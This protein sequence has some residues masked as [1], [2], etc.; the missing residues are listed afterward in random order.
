MPR[1]A[2]RP[3]TVDQFVELVEDGQKA[4][5]LDGIIYLASPE[6]DTAWLFAEKLPK[7]RACQE[8]ILASRR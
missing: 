1:R 6:F 2:T 7:R 3:I 8:K 4:D 5:L